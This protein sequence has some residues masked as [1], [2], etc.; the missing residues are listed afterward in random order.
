MMHDGWMMILGP[1]RRKLW[2]LLDRIL[3]DIVDRHMDH[4]GSHRRVPV[5]GPPGESASGPASNRRPST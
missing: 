3:A 5:E 4:E 1:L 2:G